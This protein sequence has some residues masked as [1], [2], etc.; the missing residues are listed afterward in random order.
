MVS[1]LRLVL[2]LQSRNLVRRLVLLHW[3]LTSLLLG[4]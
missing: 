3:V 1:P 2:L 4:V